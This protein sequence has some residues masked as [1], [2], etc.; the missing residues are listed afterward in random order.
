MATHERARIAATGDINRGLREAKNTRRAAVF[1]MM[2]I[3]AAFGWMYLIFFSDAF[4]I[5][6]IEVAGAKTLDPIDVTREVFQILDERPEKRPWPTRH[7]WFVDEE[8]VEKELISRLFVMK[9]SVD[10]SYSNILRLSIE[11]R[12]KRVVV[13]SHQQYFWVDL[14]GVATDELT[15]EERLDVQARLLG[16]RPIRPDEPPVIKR[17]FDE[18]INPGFVVAQTA[19]AREWIELAENVR[20]QK[21]VYRELEPPMATSSMFKVLSAEGFNVLMDITAP[22]DLQVRT[23]LEFIQ[24]KPKDITKPEYVDV[25]VPG[26]VYL[27]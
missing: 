20:A 18:P 16:T 17:E 22:L 10:K 12:S 5:N 3:G 7:A 13:H 1:A 27:K 14:Q 11:E 25:R 6:Q 15:K 19:Q 4:A 21:L 2:G 8:R 23:Y 24:N 26:R 9:A